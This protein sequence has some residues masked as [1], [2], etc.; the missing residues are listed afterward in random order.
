MV[1]KCKIKCTS[2]PFFAVHPYFTTQYFYVGFRNCQS[3][4][5][6]VLYPFICCVILNKTFE[7]SF[8]FFL[9]NSNPCVFYK[10]FSCFM[11]KNKKS[12]PVE[13][14]PNFKRLV[15]LKKSFL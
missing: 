7:N 14:N 11:I 13:F 4:A 15:P 2:F 10:K 5:Q 9:T 8:L 12:L 6:S 1:R 3:Q